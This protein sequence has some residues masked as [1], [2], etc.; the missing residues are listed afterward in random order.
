MSM[1]T[2]TPKPKPKLQQKLQPRHRRIS[3][4]KAS[5]WPILKGHTLPHL[6]RE[7]GGSGGSGESGASRNGKKSETDSR[8][9]V[10]PTT[11]TTPLMTWVKSL[12]FPVI[13]IPPLSSSK[14]QAHERKNNVPARQQGQLRFMCLN[15][16]NM[17]QLIKHTSKP[18]SNTQREALLRLARL[19][20][21][22][23][24]DV[25][26][27]VEGPSSIEKMNRWNDEFL[28]NEYTV[29]GGKDGGNQR[30]YCLVR[31]KGVLRMSATVPAAADAFFDE[32]WK[33]DVTGDCI[34]TRYKYLRRPLITEVVVGAN[35][36]RLIV[37]GVHLKSK[38]ST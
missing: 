24:P 11:T 38:V 36:S 22:V 3:P 20:R 25:A 8:F 6:P 34:M 35:K 27:V 32:R 37:I 17:D 10:T 28:N 15:A 9:E 23:D 2:P 5:K 30:V 21:N 12:S 14:L 31:K 26:T 29:L 19:L 16:E 4:T 18:M 33:V 7:R 13:N 1:P